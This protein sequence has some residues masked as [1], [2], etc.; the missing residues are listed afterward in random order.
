M[1]AVFVVKWTSARRAGTFPSMSSAASFLLAA[2]VPDL[3]D[4]AKDF[5]RTSA[6]EEPADTILWTTLVAAQLFYRAEVGHN[7]KV[8]SLDDALVFVS[9]NL[10]VGY[11]DIF[12]CTERGKQIVTLLM[13]FGPAM[14]AKALDETAAER[15]VSEQAE[16]KKHDE[17]LARLDRIAELLA[18]PVG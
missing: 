2:L 15:R 11:C 5:L 16:A 8:R 9:T 13:M 10:S 4:D 7:P 18:R 14:A 6:R 1:G 12:A 3:L 17:L